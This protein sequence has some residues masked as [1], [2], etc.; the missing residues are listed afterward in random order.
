MAIGAITI[1]EPRDNTLQAEG[2]AA[3]EYIS[4]A[5][6][7]AEQVLEDEIMEGSWEQKCAKDELEDNDDGLALEES[8]LERVGNLNDVMEKEVRKGIW[9]HTSAAYDA[10][11]TSSCGEKIWRPLYTYWTPIY[12]GISDT[13]RS[14]SPSEQSETI[15]S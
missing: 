8:N 15:G 9:Y 2:P 1:R 4:A 14:Q 5:V 13:D 3:L 10:V 7:A 12:Q 6:L 11:A